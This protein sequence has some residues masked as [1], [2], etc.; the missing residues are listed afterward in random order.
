VKDLNIKS[1]NVVELVPNEIFTDSEKITLK[2]VYTPSNSY[3][4]VITTLDIISHKLNYASSGRIIGNTTLKKMTEEEEIFKFELDLGDD[5]YLGKYSTEWCLEGEGTSVKDGS[6]AIVESTNEYVKI[7]YK[8][9]VTFDTCSLIAKVTNANPNNTQF[10]IRIDIT[11]TDDK[12][13]MTS[14]SNPKVL[15]ILRAN[16]GNVFE[17][18]NVIYK[19]EAVKLSDKEFS[20]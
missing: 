10:E 16:F 2:A 1:D 13:L 8:E 17:H 18:D 19:S 9:S 4:S 20:I 15:R 14:T 6:I 5:I 3:S 11:V 12:V 7:G